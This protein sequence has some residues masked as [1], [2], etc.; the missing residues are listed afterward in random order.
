[1][2]VVLRQNDPLQYIVTKDWVDLLGED[3]EDTTEVPD[4]LVE[5]YDRA[6]TAW[7]VVQNKLRKLVKKSEEE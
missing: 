3:Y 6:K 4:D 5:E 7:Q 1:M 2:K